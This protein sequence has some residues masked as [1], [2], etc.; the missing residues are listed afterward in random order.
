MIAMILAV[1]STNETMAQLEDDIVNNPAPISNVTKSSSIVPPNAVWTF[2]VK[3]WRLCRPD[4]SGGVSDPGAKLVNIVY[5][6]NNVFPSKIRFVGKGYEDYK[7][8]DYNTFTKSAF[9]RFQQ[10]VAFT[11]YSYIHILVGGTNTTSDGF[12]GI[13]ELA[14]HSLFVKANKIYSS[15]MIHE[16]GHNFSLLHTHY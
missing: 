16:I 10:N 14:G 3:L 7:H 2:K 9:N 12:A 8:S 6:L 13:A 5:N 1:F 15:T 11:D 4:G